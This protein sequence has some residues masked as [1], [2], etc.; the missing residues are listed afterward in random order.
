VQRLTFIAARRSLE[1]LP[2]HFLRPLPDL[3]EKSRIRGGEIFPP[4][5]GHDQGRKIWQRHDF[6]I[7]GEFRP[8]IV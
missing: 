5:R 7:P 1:N 6:E 4:E 8:G 2:F 3:R